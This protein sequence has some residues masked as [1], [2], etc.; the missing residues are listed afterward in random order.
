MLDPLLFPQHAF[1]LGISIKGFISNV[2]CLCVMV[3]IGAGEASVVFDVQYY[4]LSTRL[5]VS[6]PP[7][8]NQCNNG[9]LLI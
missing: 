3:D 8:V 2:I 9:E 7:R 4:C 6:M 1:P 5:G